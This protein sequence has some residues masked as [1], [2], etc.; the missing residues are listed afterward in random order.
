[1]DSNEIRYMVK[2][3]IPMK[4]TYH[5]FEKEPEQS[6]PQQPDPA[7]QPDKNLHGISKIVNTIEETS[8]RVIGHEMKLIR[9]KF[10]AAP[11]VERPMEFD[12]VG[13]GII[14]CS[15]THPGLANGKQIMI[16]IG[17]KEDFRYGRGFTIKIS[18]AQVEFHQRDLR[19][20]NALGANSLVKPGTVLK[21]DC[22]NWVSLDSYNGRLYFGQGEVRKET[23]IHEFNF[24]VKA[25]SWAKELKYINYFGPECD[26]EILRDAIVVNTPLK[27]V[28]MDEMTID[29]VASCEAIVP[30]NLSPEC[31]KLYANVAGK[32]FTLK[33]DFPFTDA[34]NE[35][36]K[37]ENGWCYKKI[38]EKANEFGKPDVNATYLRITL[39]L[40]QGNSPG[41][42]YV[43][44]IWPSNHYSPIHN[45][46]GV[47][48]II[49]VLDGEITTYLYSYFDKENT[50]P[51]GECLFKEGDVTYIT[52][53]LNQTHRLKNLNP[54]RACIT[55]QCYLYK[56]RDNLHYEYF[57]YIE[58]DGKR[59]GHFDPNSDMEFE[60]FRETMRQEW[61][62]N[63]NHKS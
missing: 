8:K 39:G 54:N 18:E 60:K 37:N 24:D 29:M 13:H 38:Q 63:H 41:V 17:T 50:T 16:E 1:M 52:P 62:D 49:K 14:K 10:S 33:T 56:N 45:H 43:I 26:V 34:I 35:S 55:I 15:P 30:A 48:A 20:L 61:N 40:N 32:A 4:K 3:S 36:I 9:D 6:Q 25:L 27:I 22:D 51:F 28:S 12:V 53:E 11:E 58:N 57:D 5:R 42:P 47:N 21:L 46:G 19:D 59:T 23:V 7:D 2:H 31:Q 44:E